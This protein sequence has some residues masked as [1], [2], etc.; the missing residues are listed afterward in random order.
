MTTHTDGDRPR[1]G[2]RSGS[3]L[4]GLGPWGRVGR[5]LT[6]FTLVELPAVKQRNR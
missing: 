5:S 2:S 4:W 3:W 6:G 1:D